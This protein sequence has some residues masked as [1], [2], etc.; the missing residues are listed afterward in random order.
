MVAMVALTGSCL[1]PSVGARFSLPGRGDSP[2]PRWTAGK[3]EDPRL[4]DEPHSFIHERGKPKT[5]RAQM[6]KQQ[7]EKDYI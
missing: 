4:R 6:K 1:T 5:S 2:C 7:Q 3:K